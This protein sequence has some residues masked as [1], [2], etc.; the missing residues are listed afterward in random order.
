MIPPHQVEQVVRE[1]LESFTDS[2]LKNI[3]L[4]SCRITTAPLPCVS[5]ELR[6][7]ARHRL[8]MAG[9]KTA[10]LLYSPEKLTAS[11]M[12]EAFGETFPLDLSSG[13]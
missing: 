3:L 5:E 10:E 6:A 9:S 4:S 11:E 1:L 7:L 12:S 8:H 13:T 2:G